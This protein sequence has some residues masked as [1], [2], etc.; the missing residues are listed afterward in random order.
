VYVTSFDRDEPIDVMIDAARRLP[1]VGFRMTGNPA[2]AARV[3]PPELPPN[4][5]LTGFL[6]TPAYGAL[7]QHAGVVVALT[8]DDHTMQ[9][10]A[11]EATYQGTPV[12]VSNFAILREAFDEGAIQIDNTPDALVTAIL[13]IRDHR[14]EYGQAAQRLRQRKYQR[15]L[16]TRSALLAAITGDRA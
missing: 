2:R 16:N 12:I 15:W 3:L 13:R 14:N 11:Y 4:L 9:R 6:D 5:R 1:S 7:L 8:T 10:G